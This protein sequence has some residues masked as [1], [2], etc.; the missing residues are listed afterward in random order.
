M[1]CFFSSGHSNSLQDG[2][3]LF[4]I[5][6][7][8]DWPQEMQSLL[9]LYNNKRTFCF[10]DDASR[11]T[12]R[13]LNTYSSNHG[14]VRGFEY[15]TPRKRLGAKDLMDAKEV[16]LP[17]KWVHLICAAGRASEAVAEI[18]SLGWS[19]HVRTC[20]EP[21]PNLC[22]ADEMPALEHVLPHC[23]IFSPNHTEA[24]AFF[25]G[26]QLVHPQKEA[27]EKLCGA[28][29][30]RGAKDIIVIRC[31]SMGACG[32]RRSAPTDF[33]WVPAYH[34]DQT[35]VVD[36]TGG[37]NSFLVRFSFPRELM[38]TVVL[39]WFAAGWSG[40]W[41]VRIQ[42]QSA[43]SHDLRQRQRQLL[44]RAIWTPKLCCP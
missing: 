6:R 44:H 24:Q 1:L 22:R 2:Q 25:G 27:V 18:K 20:F 14:E 11:V 41:H 8:S 30:E 43:R 12:T 7:G 40:D 31:G 42:R 26:S 23:D 28:F 9:D 39:T 36:P 37:G 16:Q 38:Y 5:D 10:R 21:V 17:P 4:V 33:L 13:S 29:F 32:V 19:Q 34:Q 15:L 35:K 3:V